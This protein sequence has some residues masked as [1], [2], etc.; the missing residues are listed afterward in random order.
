MQNNP[1][2]KWESLVLIRNIVL[3]QIFGFCQL[4]RVM[5]TLKSFFFFRNVLSKLLFIVWNIYIFWFLWADFGKV[6]FSLVTINKKSL[7][8][9]LMEV[10]VL[11]Q[12]ESLHFTTIELNMYKNL[13][14]QEI[15]SLVSISWVVYVMLFFNSVED[16]YN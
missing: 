3:A 5:K 11:L 16:R 4:V 1:Q 14:F 8:P 6:I 12:G 10:P 9:L 7:W 15:V 2:P 13:F